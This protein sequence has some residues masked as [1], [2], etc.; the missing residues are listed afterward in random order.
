MR[1]C[2]IQVEA[3]SLP[4]NSSSPETLCSVLSLNNCVG[5][6]P[7][8]GIYCSLIIQV[9]LVPLIHVRINT[10]YFEN[11]TENTSRTRGMKGSLK[12]NDR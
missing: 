7:M 3:K 1:G 5:M 8:K 2:N 12:I 11:G 6:Q 4:F 9:T 10:N